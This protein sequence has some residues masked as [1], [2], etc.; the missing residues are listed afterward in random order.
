[1]PLLDEAFVVRLEWEHLTEERPLV[2]RSVDLEL[3]TCITPPGQSFDRHHTEACIS[4][5]NPLSQWRIA[6]EAYPVRAGED[7]TRDGVAEQ[8]G[9]PLLPAGRT[10]VGVRYHYGGYDARA[11]LAIYL[12]GRRIWEDTRILT[13]RDQTWYA[14]IFAWSNEPDIRENPVRI[15][16]SPCTSQSLGAC[17]HDGL[18]AEEVLLEGADIDAE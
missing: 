14:A 6:G 18:Y 8:V 9:H 3:I 13:E 10:H 4:W 15:E 1:M 2:S 17:A 16:P 5:S 7:A 11:T 12:E